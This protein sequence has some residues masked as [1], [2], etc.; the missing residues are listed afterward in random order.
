MIFTLN[1]STRRAA[2]QRPPQAPR[3]AAGRVP[4]AW[5][6]MRRPRAHHRQ[7]HGPTSPPARDRHDPRGAADA[8]SVTADQPQS[9]A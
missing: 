4:A 9:A 8:P 3:H 5:L 7:V 1:R 2:A 6:R